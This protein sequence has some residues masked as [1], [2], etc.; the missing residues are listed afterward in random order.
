MLALP[1]LH[2][3]VGVL[4]RRVDVSPLLAAIASLAPLLPV[5]HLPSHQTPPRL[6]HWGPAPASSPGPFSTAP[7]PCA[8]GSPSSVPAVTAPVKRAAA[9]R[10]PWRPAP[11]GRGRRCTGRSRG[12]ACA[13][14]TRRTRGRQGR[15]QAAL[16][17]ADSS[18]IS[19]I[20]FCAKAQLFGLSWLESLEDMSMSIRTK[21]SRNA[22][23]LCCL[24][25]LSL[26]TMLRLLACN[27]PCHAALLL[28]RGCSVLCAC[29]PGRGKRE[30]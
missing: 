29:V 17:A 27:H 11:G 23:V 6:R 3:I 15:G 24:M 19:E 14:R 21:P 2:R 22:R 26:I 25:V 13:R 20:G 28:A 4:P 7:R 12:Q 8:P 1:L 30:T 10:A 18:L 5:P 16:Q 9:V